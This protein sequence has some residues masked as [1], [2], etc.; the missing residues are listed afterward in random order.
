ML[1]ENTFEKQ[2]PFTYLRNLPFLELFTELHPST[3]RW[4]PACDAKVVHEKSVLLSADS[5]FIC[6]LACQNICIY[7][8]LH[9]S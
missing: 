4:H 6:V 8:L 5:Y 7:F 1:Q 9:Q 2:L 3:P